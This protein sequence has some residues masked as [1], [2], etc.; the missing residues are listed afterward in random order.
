MDRLVLESY[1]NNYLNTATIKD[2]CPNGLQVEGKNEIH[3]VATAVSASLS[4]IQLAAEMGVD[5]LITH[6]S[7]FWE[8]DPYPI[9][10]AKKEKIELLLQAGISLFAYHLPL[11]AHPEVGNNW[12]AARQLGWQNLQPFGEYYGTFIGVR[13][14]FRPQPIEQLITAVETYYG[15][16]ATTALGG[17]KEISSA[18][19]IS[20]GAYK[21]IPAAALAGVDCFITGNF[22][23]P[24][25]NL[26][27]EEKIHF[28]A[29][30]HTATEKIGPKALATHL[31]KQFSIQAFFIDS[32]N[33]F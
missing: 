31:Q 18:A 10:R 2:Y 32:S 13:G 12:H 22:D 19:L 27:H 25:W 14:T 15:H 26:A 20:G 1:L 11:D 24:A 3:Q 16:P 9:I 30:G 5:A 8:K 6:H 4:T 29:L 21:E 33:P 28:L 7:L 17:K 23:E